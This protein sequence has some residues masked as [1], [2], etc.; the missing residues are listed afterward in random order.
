MHSG[1]VS[2]EEFDRLAFLLRLSGERAQG[3]G[4]PMDTSP[5][6]FEGGLPAGSHGCRGCPC[7]GVLLQGAQT[8]SCA[9]R[10]ACWGAPWLSGGPNRGMHWE[11]VP[12]TSAWCGFE[13]R[14]ALHARAEGLSGHV[15]LF[16]G[17]S[18]EAQP[19]GLTAVAD[20]L[21]DSIIDEPEAAGSR[22]APPLTLDCAGLVMGNRCILICIL[23]L[24]FCTFLP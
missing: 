11:P 8:K 2:A 4:S 21:S 19:L 20:W 3:D 23:L 5:S 12:G 1:T 22:A 10:P 7:R 13:V 15:P 16:N 6:P 9:A 14:L 17:E 18:A 24:S